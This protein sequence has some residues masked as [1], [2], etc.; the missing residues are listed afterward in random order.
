V[1]GAGGLAW[2]IAGGLRAEFAASW[3][4]A[5]LKTTEL[6]TAAQVTIRVTI[7]ALKRRPTPSAKAGLIFASSIGASMLDGTLN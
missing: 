2:L 1:A 6:S 3:A 7:L 4:N 5:G